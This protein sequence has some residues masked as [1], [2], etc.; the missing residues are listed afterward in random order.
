[1]IVSKE[2][3]EKIQI[4][5]IKYANIHAIRAQTHLKLHNVLLLFFPFAFKT[6]TFRF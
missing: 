4:K 2:P 3:L 6:S 5:E 1:M